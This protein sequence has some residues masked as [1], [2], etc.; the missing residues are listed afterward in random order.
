VRAGVVS[1]VDW[2]ITNM[3]G[4]INMRKFMHL[5]LFKMAKRKFDRVVK[6]EFEILIILIT[7]GKFLSDRVVSDRA[8]MYWNSE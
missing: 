4:K 1:G 2:K 7:Y 5:S 8:K 3:S 6:E